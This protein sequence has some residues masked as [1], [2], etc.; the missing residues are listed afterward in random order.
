MCAN[1]S[2]CFIECLS[3][4]RRERTSLADYSLDASSLFMECC[5]SKTTYFWHN[6]YT[7]WGKKLWGHRLQRTINAV[8]SFQYLVKAVIQISFKSL[9]L[10][11]CTQTHTHTCKHNL[12]TH[13][14]T[15]LKQNLPWDI[16]CTE[17]S[18][19]IHFFDKSVNTAVGRGEMN[20]QISRA[21]WLLTF[22]WV[23]IQPSSEL[24]PD[25]QRAQQ[26]TSMST[27]IYT[28]PASTFHSLP[29][30][31]IHTDMTACLVCLRASKSSPR[32]RVA[33]KVYW[34]RESKN[35]E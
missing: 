12:Q 30:Q 33:A 26:T 9:L 31:W 15:C 13:T 27:G 10:G 2:Q 24:Q 22:C 8:C 11:K 35:S 25:W 21:A 16:W 34:D 1:L 29:C 4:N 23:L 6:K 5:S 20:S 17:A 28:T 3:S 7:Q 32:S 14:H 19:E 18:E